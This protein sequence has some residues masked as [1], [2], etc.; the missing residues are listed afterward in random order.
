MKHNRLSIV[1]VALGVVMLALVVTPITSVEAIST[2]V[3]IGEF[4]TRGPNGGNDEFIELY[5]LSG[6]P[7]DISGWRLN[8]SS[9]TAVTSTRATI[10]AGTILGAYQHYLLADTATSGGPYSG[11]TTPNLTYAV[12]IADNGGLAIVDTSNIIIDQVGMNAGSAY[13]EGTILTQTLANSNQSYARQPDTLSLAG[14]HKN[15]VD[16]DNNLADF[17]FNGTSS[18]PENMASPTAITLR[19]FDARPSEL[20]L[21]A[22]IFAFGLLIAACGILTL[23]RRR[24]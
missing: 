15:G 20:P 10:P 1:V 16:T 2:T 12:G 23:R 4:R 24:A 6:T 5:N 19:H 8:G 3:V 22:F 9:S 7:V 17:I 11:G 21:A 14:G 13:K 18:S